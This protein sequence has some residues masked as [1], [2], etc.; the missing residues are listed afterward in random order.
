MTLADASFPPCHVSD[1]WTVT[2]ADTAFP[3]V[4]FVMS[5]IRSLAGTTQA[6]LEHW[7]S[8]LPSMLLSLAFW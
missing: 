4:A 1:P 7:L 8:H 2:F 6:F 5:L 3:T